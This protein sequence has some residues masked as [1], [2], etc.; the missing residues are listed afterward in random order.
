MSSNMITTNAT[1]RLWTLL[2]SSLYVRF[3]AEA[4]KTDDAQFFWGY[5]SF[6]LVR[7]QESEGTHIDATEEDI[8]LVNNNRECSHM[9]LEQNSGD[10]TEIA[11]TFDSSN[12]SLFSTQPRLF[13]LPTYSMMSG[14]GKHEN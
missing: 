13:F 1:K 3:L 8:L 14:K 12:T 9:M 7:R 11:S 2:V 5:F 6:L 4:T 10:E